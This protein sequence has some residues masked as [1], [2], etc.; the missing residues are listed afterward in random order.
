MVQTSFQQESLPPG[1][2]SGDRLNRYEFERR[3]NA[4]HSLQKAELIE[5]VVYLPAALSFRR[6]SQP[7]A[8]LILWLGRVSMYLCP[9]MK[10]M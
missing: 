7:H 5:G 10:G 1:I 3:Y 9:W 2:E 6:H 4:M 8:N